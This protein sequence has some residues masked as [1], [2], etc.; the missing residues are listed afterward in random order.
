MA[1]TVDRQP[2]KVKFKVRHRNRCKHC[3]RPRSFMRKFEMCRMCFRKL[4]LSGDVPGVIKSS[5]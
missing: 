1:T 2:K 5:W 4:S 3:G